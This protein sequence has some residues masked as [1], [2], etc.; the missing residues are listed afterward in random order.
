MTF[1]EQISKYYDY[2]FP[3]GAEQLEFI[4]G[5]AGPAP[6]KL[7]DIACGSGGYSVELAKQGYLMTALDYDAGMV[8]LAREKAQQG[9]LHLK[10]MQ[11]DMKKLGQCVEESFDGVF[12]IGNSIVHLGSHNEIE[13][14]LKQM[15]DTLNP[16]GKLIL[17]V[18][19]YDRIIE[20]GIN[21][22]PVLENGEIG[23]RF[24]RKYEFDEDKG[25]IRFITKLDIANEDINESYNNSIELLP[26]QS[27]Q[28]SQLLKNSG[29]ER[30]RFYGDFKGSEYSVDSYLLV[31]EAE[32]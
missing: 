11:C 10:V 14:A 13:V 26:L 17:Q 2:I 9:N 16:G 8:G 1:Y 22:L 27:G 30:F 18:I 29:F 15:H 5:S 24:I 19:N 20:F 12:C 28:L 4:K 23:L 32:K 21:E 31:V 3:T 25:L 7:L 6:K